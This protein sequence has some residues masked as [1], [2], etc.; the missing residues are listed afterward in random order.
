[1]KVQ[2]KPHKISMPLNPKISRKTTWP[3]S[4]TDLEK[5]EHSY[6]S[7]FKSEETKIN[8]ET[9]TVDDNELIC[10]RGLIS[11]MAAM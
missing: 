2:L 8:S 5:D 7:N 9:T 3:F 1:M 6:L 11:R 4:A 10:F